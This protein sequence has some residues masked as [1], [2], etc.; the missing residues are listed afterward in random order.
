ML[1]F[2]LFIIMQQ[3]GGDTQGRFNS[4]VGYWWV[5]L[6]LLRKK[7]P[8]ADG[9]LSQNAFHSSWFSHVSAPFR[10][11]GVLCVPPGRFGLLLL[12]F[13]PPFFKPPLSHFTLD[14]ISTVLLAS[15]LRGFDGGFSKIIPSKSCQC[16]WRSVR[17]H[18]VGGRYWPC[19][20]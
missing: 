13:F 18:Q 16:S 7:R 19:G 20:R 14:C 6:S 2:C 10:R 1:T 12:L 9:G 11:L 8:S 3:L 5:V 17:C 4:C 15:N